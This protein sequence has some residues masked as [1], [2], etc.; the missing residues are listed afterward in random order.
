MCERRWPVVFADVA[1]RAGGDAA[2]NGF[3]PLIG[4][5]DQN[6][7]A[8]T[9]GELADRTHALKYSLV[10]SLPV[11]AQVQDDNVAGLA[12]DRDECFDRSV[13]AD[14]YKPWATWDF[15]GQSVLRLVV[16]QDVLDRL[17][18]GCQ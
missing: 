2:R 11:E 1:S 3:R 17:A 13:A 16:D 15:D 4:S 7:L 9:A 12:L 6:S 18:G 10:A 5:E 14:E 8:I